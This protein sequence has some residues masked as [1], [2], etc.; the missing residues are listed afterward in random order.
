MPRRCHIEPEPR[1]LKAGG[2]S[3]G[4][5]LDLLEHVST[6]V[7]LNLSRRHVR[8]ATGP[9]PSWP[10]PHR[11][12]K[13]SG[14]GP[15]DTGAAPRSDRHICHWHEGVHPPRFDPRAKGGHGAGRGAWRRTPE[16]PQRPH[17]LGP[18]P[19]RR[20]LS[21][22]RPRSSLRLKKPLLTAAVVAT[23]SLA[24][25]CASSLAPRA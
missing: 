17:W 8:V 7:C 4:H 22:T 15:H 18:W 5:G 11:I 24:P 16:P 21:R 13:P 23:D 3:A 25:Y 20:S 2:S 10:G 6:Q 12:R 9:K 14:Q 19:I 1:C